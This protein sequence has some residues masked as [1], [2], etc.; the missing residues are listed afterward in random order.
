MQAAQETESERFVFCETHGRRCSVA[1][2]SQKC[3]CCGKR[4]CLCNYVL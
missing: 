2:G 1:Q 3:P 4:V